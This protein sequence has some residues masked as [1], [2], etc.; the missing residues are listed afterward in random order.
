MSREPMH[1]TDVKHPS[2]TPSRATAAAAGGRLPYQGDQDVHILDRI[3]AIDRYRSL[4]VTVFL[5]I[6]IGALVKTYTTVPTYRATSRVLI[7]DERA[8][9]VAGFDS[10]ANPDYADESG[11]YYNTQLKLLTRLDLAGK[12]VERLHLENVPEFNGSGPQ[13]TALSAVLTRFYRRALTPLGVAIDQPEPDALRPAQQSATEEALVD[14]FLSRVSVEPVKYSGLVDVSFV[15]AD[16]AFA[17]RAADALVE[18]YVEQNL[19]LRLQTARKSLAWLAQE[20]GKQ[21]RK[22]EA[23]ERAMAEYREAQDALSLEDRQNIVVAR[24]NQLNDVV[25]RAKTARV[26][27]EAVYNQIKSLG[28]TA[29]ADTIAVIIQNSYIQSIKGRLAELQREKGRLSGRYGDK[30]PEIVKVDAGIQDA[31]RQLQSELTKSI[32]AVR[33]DYQSALAEET[34]LT[35]ALEEQKGLAMALNRKSVSY[36]VLERE[37]Q[38]NRQVYG[39]LLQREKE[40]QV[41][42]NSQG[43]NVR[44]IDRARVPTSPFNPNPSRNLM[45]GALAG[46]ALAIG[47]VLGLDHLDD[48]VKTPEDITRKLKLPFLGLVPSVKTDG[49]LLLTAK[50]PYE[51]GEAFRSLRTSLV[52]SSEGEATRV[53]VVTSA[54][55]LEGKTTTACNLAAA[56]SCGGARVLL[57][58]ADMRR[59]SV[60]RALGLDNGRGLSDL[61]TGQAPLTGVVQRLA[62]PDLWVMTAGRTPPNPSE[63]L[64]SERMNAL[65][66]RARTGPF[67]WVIV[68]TPPLLGMTD[69]L[70]LTPWAS[71][72]A[73]VVGSEITSRRLVERGIEAL[74]TSKAK[75]FGAVLNRVDLARNKYYYSRYYGYGY[76]Y[77]KKGYAR[78]AAA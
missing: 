74:T 61:L 19:D 55:P 22:V 6:V 78:S 75:I 70:I 26:Q 32:E 58:D 62:E 10:A 36:T 53:V 14:A 15:S 18:E 54:Q 25:T 28:A 71:G 44:L 49:P 5:L 30:H 31:S 7:Q 56:L 3:I 45:L 27:K 65:M 64:A 16:P 77:Y 72:V 33:N 24:L 17:A 73:L 37:A 12:V 43:N 63:L 38:S 76:N 4:F 23:S 51:F 39:T 34:T 68:D 13:P 41:A 2:A 50:V 40:Q 66:A 59:P 69:A 46:L 42:S 57:I 9:A 21:Q 60:H 47:V 29:S 48:T 35:A 20:I 67:D 52:F 11:S 8:A 1:S